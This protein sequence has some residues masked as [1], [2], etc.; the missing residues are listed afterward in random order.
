[1]GGR[2][3]WAGG[4][5]CLARAGERTGA[6]LL[7]RMTEKGPRLVRVLKG[8]PPE[9]LVCPPL[10]KGFHAG[11]GD[12]LL[13]TTGEETQFAPATEEALSPYYGR[14]SS[15]LRALARLVD[16]CETGAVGEVEEVEFPSDLPRP[17][18][19]GIRGAE[20]RGTRGGP[21]EERAVLDVRVKV[22]LAGA[23]GKRLRVGIPRAFAGS[24]ARVGRKAFFLRV[25][26]ATGAL[27][28]LDGGMLELASDLDQAALFF[29]LRRIGL[30]LPPAL[31]TEAAT[32]RVWTECWNSKDFEGALLCYSRESAFRRD[33]DAVRARFESYP[34]AVELQIESV[35]RD[36]GGSTVEVAATATI[37]DFVRTSRCTIRFVE[38]EGETLILDDGFAEAR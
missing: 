3:A 16:S 24:E 15:R 6:L 1:M 32:L 10:P 19:L 8:A 17:R 33:A 30:P 29:S 14:L 4:V 2:L 25:D 23:P 7:A 12:L 18:G 11:E 31:T 13:V 5:L 36:G 35:E 9:G 22:P 26:D 27:V 38:E 20:V 34:A 37:G 21:G 28:P